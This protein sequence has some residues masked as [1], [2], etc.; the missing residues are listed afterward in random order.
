MVCG[1]FF[2]DFG[3]MCYLCGLKSEVGISCLSSGK[4]LE[5][6]IFDGL[7]GLFGLVGQTVD[8]CR[9]GQRTCAYLRTLVIKS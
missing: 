3:K 1:F 4:W 2:G 9:Y 8:S 5:M 6:R 7:R